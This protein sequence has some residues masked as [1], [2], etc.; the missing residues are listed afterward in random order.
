MKEDK[1][2]LLAIIIFA[3][4]AE[5]IFC[6]FFINQNI[7]TQ[8]QIKIKINDIRSQ[9][10]SQNKLK[11]NKDLELNNSI[12]SIENTK[13]WEHYSNIKIQLNQYKD[14]DPNVTPLLE[15]NKTD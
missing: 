8:N 12:D 6:V 3:F 15:L 11:L 13:A 5:C 10:A 4:V 9:E 1:K 2:I 7:Y 14:R